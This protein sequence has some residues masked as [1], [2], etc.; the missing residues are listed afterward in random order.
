MPKSH[1]EILERVK[2]SL[3]DLH[4][5]ALE[6]DESEMLATLLMLRSRQASG[7]L[8]T[9]E[10]VTIVQLIQAVRKVRH[11]LPIESGDSPFDYPK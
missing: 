1:D 10:E 6:I 5:L 11:C 3:K 8:L 9:F 7:R 2:K 4:K